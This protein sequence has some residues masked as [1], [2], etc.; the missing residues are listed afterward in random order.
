VLWQTATLRSTCTD[1]PRAATRTNCC[2]SLT[3]PVLSTSCDCL[4]YSAATSGETKRTAVVLKRQRVVST[5]WDCLSYS[6]ATS[7]ETKRTA[8]VLK[9]QRVM[10]TSCVCLS[11]SLYLAATSG[12]TKRTADVLKRHRVVSISW[13]DCLLCYPAATSGE[14]CCRFL[15]MV[16]LSTSCD[17]LYYSA[18]TSGDAFVSWG[19]QFCRFDLPHSSI[20]FFVF[21]WLT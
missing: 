9:R 1:C 14:N 13:W 12:E 16:I 6:A 21:V 7:G 5:S 11:Y 2:R 20:L 19:I 3:K 10:S 8:V 15:A 4:S 17:C 18:A